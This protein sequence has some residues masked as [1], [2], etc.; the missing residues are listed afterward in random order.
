MCDGRG[1][2]GSGDGLASSGAG[3]QSRGQ[4][5]ALVVLGEGLGGGPAGR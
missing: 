3:V 1:I 2:R 4:S 5:Q